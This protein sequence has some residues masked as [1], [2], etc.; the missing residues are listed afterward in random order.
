[1]DVNAG[2]CLYLPAGWFHNVTSFSVAQGSSSESAAPVPPHAGE[3]GHL[4]FNYWFHPPDT[5]DFEKP[6]STTFWEEDWAA[7]G[8][9]M[10]VERT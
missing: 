6:Y 7:R 2:E 4:A 9:V 10:A 5:A 3:G 8:D 1:V